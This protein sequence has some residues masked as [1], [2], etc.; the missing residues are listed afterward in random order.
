MTDA[1][2]STE[3]AFWRFSLKFY[4]QAGVSDACIA[5]QDEHGVDVNLMLFLLW[6][7]ADHRKLSPPE[8][9]ALDDKVSTWRNL[10]IVPIRHV[11]RKL[12]G[13]ATFVAPAAQ[14][15]FRTKVK[16]VELEAERLQQEALNQFTRSSPPDIEVSPASAA[17]MNIAAYQ[18]VLE[19]SFP[20]AVLDVLF[21]AFD[22]LAD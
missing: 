20:G 3:N 10:T 6:L 22:E 18:S 2:T 7:A 5:L 14:E 8:V 13:A 21:A 17:R 16:A 9:K 1:A 11:R 19:A 15:A 12:K 4:R